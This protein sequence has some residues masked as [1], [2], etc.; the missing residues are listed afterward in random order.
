MNR[1]IYFN[2]IEEKLNFL[3][4]RIESRGGLNL[5]DFNIH[6][7]PFCTHFLNLL[8]DWNLRNLNTVQQNT[9]GVDLVDHSKKVVIQ[10]S[11]TAT[12]QKVESALAK[13]LSAYQS[14]SFKFIAISKDASKL[15]SKI[16]SNPHKLAFSPADDIYDVPAL[17]KIIFSMNIERQKKI[18]EFIK[19]ELKAEPDPV[20][21]ETNL[22]KIIDIISKVDW[23]QGVPGFETMPYDIEPKII[24]NQLDKARTLIDEYKVHYNRIAKIYSDFDKQGVNKSFSVLNGIHMEYLKLKTTDSPDQCFFII[25]DEVIKK[26]RESANYIPIPSDELLVCVQVLVVDAFIRCK[27]FKNPKGIK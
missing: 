12:K 7:E 20:K 9:A 4:R 6:A 16:F 13:D 5:L 11:A 14:Y 10:V 17:L 21:I 8:F 1:P 18:H 27:I 26:I 2:Y 23:A 25:I 3:A 24:Y 15:R 22:A 19:L